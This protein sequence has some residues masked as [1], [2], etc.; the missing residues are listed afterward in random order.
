MSRCEGKPEYTQYT[1]A[2]SSQPDPR[3]ASVVEDIGIS[4]AARGGGTHGE[5]RLMF[6][7]FKGQYKPRLHVQ[8]QVFMDGYKAFM[9]DRVQNSIK[10]IRRMTKPTPEKVIEALE[11]NGITASVYHMRGLRH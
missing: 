2:W 4:F 8:V 1:V 7:N 6:Y 3:S 5:F 9:D 10:R 11:G